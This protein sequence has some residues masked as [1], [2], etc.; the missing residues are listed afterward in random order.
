MDKSPRVIPESQKDDD[1][2]MRSEPNY[3]GIKAMPYIV[4]N[5]YRHSDGLHLFSLIDNAI[6]S[7]SNSA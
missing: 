3:R 1:E 4:G 5:D 2:T 6:I 7:C